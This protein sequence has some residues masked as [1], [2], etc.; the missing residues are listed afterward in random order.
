MGDK[1]KIIVIGRSF[2]SGGRRIGLEIARRLGIPFYD[3][4][5][6]KRASSEF[7]YSPEIFARADEKRPSLLKRI[8][9]QSYGIAES[10]QPDTISIESLYEI[11]SR[12]IRGVAERSDCVIV[13]R[14][15]DYILRNNPKLISIFIHS[16]AERRACNI[17]AR[18][19]A[20]NLEKAEE[21][22]RKID[23]ERESYYNFFTGRNWG[24]ASNYHLSLDSSS[25]NADTIVEIV[26]NIYNCK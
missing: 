25:L 4:E 6:L 11:Q 19:E 8:V 16:P 24:V 13:G 20:P 23:K 22:V 18:G 1:N 7:G 26:T 15:A 5:L 3:R 10:Y 17:V 2:G 14:T 12:V 21:L 9:S